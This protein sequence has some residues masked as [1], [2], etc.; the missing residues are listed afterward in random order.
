MTTGSDLRKRALEAFEA[1]A[2]LP[3]RERAARLDA[4]CGDDAALRARVE[5]MLA[6]DPGE[7]EPFPIDATP[8][9]NARA[10]ELPEA[11]MTGRGFGAW[12]V[13]E[14]IGR[15]GMGAVYAVERADGAY[16]Q[17]AA[18][19]L[20]RA[21]A[22]SPVARER[23]LRE[24]QLLA[25]LH[26]PNIATLL[27]GGISEQGDPWFVMEFVDGTPIDRW[28]DERA[29]GLRERVTLFLQVL[30]AVAHAHRNLV[31][32]RDLKPSNLLV[33]GDGRVKLLDFGIAKQLEGGDA[34][35][36]SDR[37]L[38][39]EYASPEQ[40][41]D[42]PITTATDIW[43]LGIV[44]HRLL[45]AS[46]PFGLTRD[47]PLAKQLQLLEREPEPLTRA[48]TQA[49]TEQAAQR[50]EP[51]GAALA[52]ALRGG[53][54][55][56]VETCLRRQPDARYPSA[57]ALATDL[58]R[59]LEHRPVQAA[60][61]GRS[62][63]AM[64]W[65][66][67]NRLL[68]ASIGAV[69]LALLAGIGVALWQASEAHA[70]ARIAEQQRAEAQ[71]QGATAKA[72]LDFLGNAMLAAL[73][74]QALDTKVS[75]RQLLGAATRKLDQDKQLSPDVR[76]A[77]QR[78]LGYMYMTLGEPKIAVGLFEAG[79]KHVQPHARDDALALADDISYYSNALG[80]LE[81]G[82]ESLVQA[83]RA[84]AMRERY[85]P[86]DKLARLNSLYDL[87]Y[88]QFRTGDHAAA[89]ASWKQ[90]IAMVEAMPAPPSAAITVYSYLASLYGWTGDAKGA[91][92]TATKGL[93][94]AD[95]AGIPQESPERPGLL[96]AL[97][98][99]QAISGDQA[100]AE[101]SIRQ[102][103]A[104]SE[105]YM[106]GGADIGKLYGSLGLVL[107]EQGRY[108]EALEAMRHADALGAASDDVPLEVAIRKEHVGSVYDRLG[109]YPAALQAY[110]AA[111]ATLAGI[112]D[113]NAPGVKRKLRVRQARIA[114][115]AGKAAWAAAQLAEL[116]GQSLKED[117]EGSQDYAYVVL[118]QA[119]AAQRMGDA[120][121]AARLLD[122]ANALWA[123]AAPATHPIFAHMLRTRAALTR[124]RG[125]LAT[126]E[127]DQRD[128]L[129][130]LEAGSQPIDT[131]TARAE[132]AAIRHQQGQDT[133]ARALLAQA[134]PVLRD[135]VLPQQADR[136]AAEALAKQLG[137]R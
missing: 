121:R 48:A 106:E 122:E 22:D 28:C 50:G 92:E 110:D 90:A 80:T 31:I 108:R 94:F 81:R 6:A 107:N 9:G 73:P 101:R 11:E 115:R 44:L 67:R 79:L 12:R 75:A 63:R 126:A 19:K 87:G 102:A 118:Q 33:D 84:A 70:Q 52:K 37:A 130:R 24:R 91:L 51:D 14:V 113:G 2:D 57:D 128:A 127:R 47:T 25:Q 65:L 137:M 45:G 26:H 21:A 10:P 119:V 136:A 38:T 105:K 82:K 34:T 76:Q 135:A 5:A 85:A 16:A 111:I 89:E 23:F 131:A 96:R 97:S 4:L 132:L 60:Q 98:D 61:L 100:G 71:R 56:I 72:S 114:A 120:G 20:I 30:D 86:E 43:Q 13:L 29:L 46:H 53:L 109:D 64:L 49:S 27:D 99:A 74:D 35:A 125:D 93:A 55:A 69:A 77:M 18:L 1:I 54:A 95:R 59:W 134:L 133:D 123:K 15:G 41:H 116:R 62:E 40:L 88:A 66:R 8:L 39:F 78:K 103:I 129:Q 124:A 32:H 3:A 68:A 117:G 36:T 58:H 7:D 17:H 112:D 42:A 104:L 83:K